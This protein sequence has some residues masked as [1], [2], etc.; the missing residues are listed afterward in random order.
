MRA[1]VFIHGIIGARM[2]LDGK[3]IWPPTGEEYLNKR[4][5]RIKELLTP[6]A[7]ATRII[8]RVQYGPFIKEVYKPI[9][10]DLEKIAE[11]TKSLTELVPYDWRLDNW[12]HGT[13][14]LA[15]AMGRVE[16]RGATSVTL[17]CH[18]MGGLICR[19]MLETD[20]YKKEKWVQKITKVIFVCTP[21]LGAAR[22]LGFAL[23]AVPETDY[24]IQK[25]DMVKLLGDER[26]PAGYQCMPHMGR[27][28]LYDE[29]HDPRVPQDIYLPEV[30]DKYGLARS[31][32]SSLKNVR[33][34]LTGRPPAVKYVLVAG[35][36][37]D[38]AA[39]FGFK[40]TTYRRTCQITLGDGTVAISSA[41]PE[42][43]KGPDDPEPMPGGHLDIFA[44]G[45][46]K[47]F[48][49]KELGGEKPPTPMVDGRPRV[50][51]SLQKDFV[52]QGEEISV[53][54]I[55]D[56][57]ATEISGALKLSKISVEP[58]PSKTAHRTESD[59]SY[60]GTPITHL[61]SRLAA[62]REQGAYMVEFEGSHRSDES[63]AAILVVG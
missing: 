49:Y 46:F 1:L 50:V 38:T 34:L 13:E 30:D 12:T 51:V 16:C 7:V 17:I 55:P 28:V 2:E 33:E 23:P 32:I 10:D 21:H 31:N 15:S 18:S 53:L 63:S 8:D 45:E 36:D 37:H 27:D 6:T 19:L 9:L 20:K 44:T 62:P 22:P 11:Q 57:A 35:K 5:K 41:Q 61:A 54:I 39:A 58:R 24:G 43:M 4:Y 52:R 60:R 3:E 25:A 47:K 26:Y 40:G 59:L 42:K 56:D 29:S 14:A 48:L